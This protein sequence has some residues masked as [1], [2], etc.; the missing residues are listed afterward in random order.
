MAYDIVIPNPAKA[1]EF[2]ETDKKRVMVRA[3]RRGGKT[4]GVAIFQ[5]HGSFSGN[6]SIH[7]ANHRSMNR[8]WTETCPIFQDPIDPEDIQ[9]N[10]T[11]HILEL[12]GTERRIRAKTAWNADTFA[13]RLCR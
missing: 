2:V 5:P 1:K 7:S 9:Q 12:P 10:S 8:F 13:R 11:R 4:V 6:A 3:G